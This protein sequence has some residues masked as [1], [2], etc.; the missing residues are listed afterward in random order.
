MSRPG[1]RRGVSITSRC[2][3]RPGGET[4]SSGPCST[5]PD[6]T[7]SSSIHNTFQLREVEKGFLLS[8]VIELH[9]IELK[10]FTPGKPHH[11]LTPFEKWL[12]ILKFSDV[13]AP[14]SNPLPE[15]LVQ[16]EGITMAIDSMRKAYA[17]DEVREM[18]LAREKAERDY[19]SGIHEAREEG[20][21]EGREQGLDQGL[22][23]VALRMLASGL[24][25]EQ[26]Q[27]LTGASPEDLSRWLGE[28]G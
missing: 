16:E 18:I 27:E 3:W 17:V 28:S 2:N 6:C 11:L 5:L 8:D 10:K 23:Q 20:L 15:I 24:A 9:Y 4:T 1:T 26:I 14:E 19:L 13:Y 21:E 22:R 25:R 7:A 12:Y